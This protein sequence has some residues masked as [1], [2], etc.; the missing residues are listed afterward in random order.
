MIDL[1]KITAITCDLTNCFGMFGGKV[2][3]IVMTESVL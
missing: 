1:T 2:K 3:C